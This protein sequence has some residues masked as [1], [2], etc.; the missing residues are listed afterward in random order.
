MSSAGL[1]NSFAALADDSDS[2]FTLVPTTSRKTSSAAAAATCPKAAPGGSSGRRH[3]RRAIYKDPYAVSD[4]GYRN[5]ARW[6]ADDA[7]LSGPAITWHQR[8]IVTAFARIFSEIMFAA[9][10]AEGAGELGTVEVMDTAGDTRRAGFDLTDRVYYEVKTGNGADADEEEV[11][12]QLG[13]IL[14][15]N[16]LKLRDGTLDWNIVHREANSASRG[17][18]RKTDWKSVLRRAFNLGESFGTGEPNEAPMSVMTKILATRGIRLIDR[19]LPTD[20]RLRLFIE[21]V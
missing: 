3:R 16:P 5:L 21:P 7:Y 6:A 13:N 9:S 20:R 19:T 14:F 18:W 1:K 17:W 11:S 4:E 10:C 2:E 12:R 15:G 8:M